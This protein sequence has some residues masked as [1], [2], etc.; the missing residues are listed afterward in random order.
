[1]A[2]GQVG[3]VGALLDALACQAPCLLALGN[4]VGRVTLTTP[5]QPPP[6]S[7]TRSLSGPGSASNS[8]SGSGL[9]RGHSRASSPGLLQQQQ[10][11]QSEEQAGLGG[12]PP[13]D[14]AAMAMAAAQQAAAAVYQ[15]FASLS[16]GPSGAPDLMLG[17]PSGL[18]PPAGFGGGF[19]DGGGGGG[20]EPQLEVMQELMAMA[21]RQDSPA[22]AVWAL[23][24]LQAM[25]G[26]DPLPGFGPGAPPPFAG[27]GPEE[28]GEPPLGAFAG[29]G[30][31]GGYGSF[32]SRGGGPGSAAGAETLGSA[33][34]R[35]HGGGGGGG[36]L[37]RWGSASAGSELQ[38]ALSGFSLASDSGAPLPMAGEASDLS[39][40]HSPT[41]S[42]HSGSPPPGR[43]RG[44]GAS[45][46]PP[47]SWRTAE[48]GGGGGGCCSGTRSTFH[49]D[50]VVA[51]PGRFR[52]IKK[53]RN[54]YYSGT[55]WGSAGGGAGAGADGAALAGMPGGGPAG[56]G[57]AAA[58]EGPA[59]AGDARALA[60]KGGA[61]GYDSA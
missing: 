1:V 43:G 19:E 25:V 45:G 44:G 9:S 2:Q 47:K 37:V 48:L 11:Q 55:H 56:G 42:A 29:K 33:G 14:V 28:P 17:G 35:L 40:A 39:L 41:G 27:A 34:C 7:R 26:P 24:Q 31:G 54:A 58:G 51:S 16:S 8:V 50:P 18:G 13:P 57:G 23:Q 60:A 10:Q 32:G 53:G 49:L 6:P 61:P 20:G 15:Q 4:C 5:P 21:S 38:R 3:W 12:G 52:R 36:G 30:G 59:A 46:V 22:V